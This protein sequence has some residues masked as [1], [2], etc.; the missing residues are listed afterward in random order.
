MEIGQAQDLSVDFEDEET[1][2]AAIP[3]RMA[4]EYQILAQVDSRGIEGDPTA[5]DDPVVLDGG[6]RYRLRLPDCF[7][8]RSLCA[9]LKR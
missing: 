5:H 7:V 1:G 6:W 9:S 4:L 2:G 8:H 3:G